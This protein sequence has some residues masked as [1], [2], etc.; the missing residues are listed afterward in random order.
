MRRKVLRSQELPAAGQGERPRHPRP[1]H[2]QGGAR[3]PLRAVARKS[4]VTRQCSSY[5]RQC[6]V[7]NNTLPPPAP[8][9]L[10]TRRTP[11]G[12]GRLGGGGCHIFEDSWFVCLPSA[13][14]HSRAPSRPWERPGTH[15]HGESAE[16]ERERDR[17]QDR[18]R[19]RE[20]FLGKQWIP[21]VS[22][23]LTQHTCRSERASRRS[24][25]ASRAS[26]ASRVH[27]DRVWF[28]CTLASGRGQT[29]E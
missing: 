19:D 6:R 12:S 25:R 23:A 22:R 3:A 11:A 7:F 9:S 29:G 27:R 26:R 14:Q 21:L 28:I 18:D 17:D 20:P 5:G 24:E 4:V 2:P 8:E 10:R 16:R 1:R 13:P 15:A